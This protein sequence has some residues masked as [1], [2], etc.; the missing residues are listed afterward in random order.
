MGKRRLWAGIV[1][2]A[3]VATVL[4]SATQA[5]AVTG[6]CHGR[7][8]T[9]A[10]TNHGEWVIG[11]W[12]RDII[13]ARGGNDHVIGLGRNDVICGGAGSDTIDGSKGG[14]LVFGGPGRDACAATTSREH[15]LHHHCEAHNGAPLKGGGGPSAA[16]RTRG[17]ER[18]RSVPSIVG[19]NQYCGGP[20]CDWVTVSNNMDCNYT[21]SL[22]NDGQAVFGNFT[23]SYAFRFVLWRLDGSTWNLVLVDDWHYGNLMPNDSDFILYSQDVSQYGPGNFAV[24]VSAWFWNG[25][26]WVDHTVTYPLVYELWGGDFFGVPYAWCYA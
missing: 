15:R 18:A 16:G 8:V 4:V 26:T 1:L 13:N 20:H 22:I 14:D 6:K 9:I 7:R 25:S 23:G 10:G 12:H 11:T 2:P 5:H 21:T 17:L 3:L 24:G 19:A